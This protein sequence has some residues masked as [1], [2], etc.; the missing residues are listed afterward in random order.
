MLPAAAGEDI[1]LIGASGAIAALSGIYLVLYPRHD[2]HMAV[3]FRL[4]WW[5]RVHIKT[6]PMT[7][8]YAV[9][10]YTAFDVAAV[11]LGWTGQVAH[12]VHLAGFLWGVLLGLGLLLTRVV[13]SE[14]Y[15][16]LSWVLG[17]RWQRLGAKG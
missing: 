11:V 17:D 4:Y 10:F 13:P 15:D 3:W 1:P 9:L 14:G 7:G 5:T 8:L 6:F 12:W 16:L 2:I